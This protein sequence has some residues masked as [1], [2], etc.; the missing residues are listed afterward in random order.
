MKP[1]H[2]WQRGA[3]MA[4][5]V[6]AVALV[7]TL[8]SPLALSQQGT[9]PVPL[10][11]AGHPVDWWFAFKL[12]AGVFPGCAANKNRVCRFGGDTSFTQGDIGQQFVFARSEDRALQSGHD[13]LGDETTDPVGA[14]FDEVYNGSLYYVVWNEK[15]YKDPSID[16]STC[17]L[18]NEN[19]PGPWGHS[20]GMLA[21][22]DDGEGFVMQVTTPDWPGSAS[23]KHARA[24]GNTLGCTMDNNVAYRQ[25]FFALKLS[26]DD[27]KIVLNALQ[28][29][30]VA[31]RPGNPKIVHNGGPGDIQALVSELGNL[32]DD[33]EVLNQTLSSGVILIAKPS[34]LHVPPWQWCQQFLGLGHSE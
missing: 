16:P 20:K 31:T 9:A 10:V 22:N 34:A 24:R 13:C 30:S 5:S 25:S 11:A 21:W 7:T 28:R 29:A 12:N 4:V 14:T 26:R 27:L 33:T 15:F 6:A 8:V 17:T 23:S 32:S 18:G 3:L 2:V 1:A 19:C